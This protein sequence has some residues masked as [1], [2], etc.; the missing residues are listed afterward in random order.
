LLDIAP[1]HVSW[2]VTLLGPVSSVAGL[3]RRSGPLRKIPTPEGTIDYPVEVDT[4]VTSILE[5]SSGVVGTFVTSFDVWSHR[6]PAIEIYGS[7]GTLSLP[8]PNWYDGDV[9][10]KRHDDAEWQV[11]EPVFE[12][13][14]THPTE[15]VRGLGVV[16]LI[17]SRDG[18]PNRTNSLLAFHTLEVLEAMQS[19]SRKRGFVT[20]ESKPDPP[21]PLTAQDLR[22]WRP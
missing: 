7:L 3:S 22:R 15:K 8:H 20:I 1:Y 5:F 2:L 12:P 17:D 14:Q 19:S 6:L 21:P 13:I 9:E 18:A 11:V 10:L 16:D 4:H